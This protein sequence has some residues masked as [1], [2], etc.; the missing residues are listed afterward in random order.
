MSEKVF[1]Q[2][3]EYI[4]AMAVQFGVATEYVF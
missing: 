3:M 4:D 2:V 1:E